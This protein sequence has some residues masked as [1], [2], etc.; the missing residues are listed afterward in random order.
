MS[1]YIKSILAS[2]LFFVLLGMIVLDGGDS[3]I[4]FEYVLFQLVIVGVLFADCMQ[5]L[6]IKNHE[7]LHEINVILGQHPND[8]DIVNYFIFCMLASG[9]FAYVLP[10]IVRN[11]FQ[12]GLIVMEIV[13]IKANIK[14]GMRIVY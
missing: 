1:N 6:D 13:V 7:N 14:L 5:T 4:T 8:T 9:M 11:I 10:E 2:V 12:V 3:K